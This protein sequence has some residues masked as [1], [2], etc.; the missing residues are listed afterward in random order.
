MKTAFFIFFLE[1]G[2]G[3]VLQGLKLLLFVI[4]LYSAYVYISHSR[5]VTFKCRNASNNSI[6]L[7]KT[8]RGLTVLGGKGQVVSVT[9]S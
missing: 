6:Y 8:S 1:V 2:L 9:R 7:M 4:K 3:L 5:I